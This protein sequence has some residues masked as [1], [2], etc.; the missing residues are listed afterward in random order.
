[1]SAALESGLYTRDSEYDCGYFFTEV[2]GIEPHDWTYDHY[3]EDG[4]TQPSGRLNLVEG[5][6]R[7]CNPWFMHIGVDFF[8]RGMYT[9][10]SDMARGFGLGSST[11]IEIGDL[12]GQIPDP[13]SEVDAFNLAIA[14]GNTQVTPLQ[15]ARFVAAIGNGG[16]LYRPQLIE[17]IQPVNG[18]PVQT[19]KPE[20]AGTVPITTERLKAIQDAM[21][22]VVK[23]P[24]GTAYYRLLG[25][26]L[27]YAGKTGTAQTGEGLKPE[28][29]FIGYTEDEAF[30]GLPDI[31]IAVILENQGEGSDW[32][33]PVFRG[34]VQA[35]YYGSIQTIPWF[36]PYDD[37]YTPTP[38]GGVPTKVPRNRGRAT[39][40]P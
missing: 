29:W 26:D 38:F 23:D 9:A 20:A 22:M 24:R 11:G 31:A 18:D 16:T 12:A 21:R 2:P 35:Y 34:I 4:R 37:L 40:T 13:T 14:Q 5:L 27:P 33:A 36:G 15:V 25:L 17:K 30:S 10:I 28:A 8:R 3:L 1:M 32:A 19:F 39:P 6:M 7:S